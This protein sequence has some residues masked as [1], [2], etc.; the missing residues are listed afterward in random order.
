[1][2]GRNKGMDY[3]VEILMTN[4]RQDLENNAVVFKLARR[5]IVSPAIY[6]YIVA[7]AYKSRGQMFRESLKS[8]VARWNATGSEDSNAHN[9]LGRLNVMLLRFVRPFV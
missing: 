3:R 6:R 1:M 5:N 2:E 8:A 9:S 4:R 7:A